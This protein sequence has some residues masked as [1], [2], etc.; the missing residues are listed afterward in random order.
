MTREAETSEQ[1]RRIGSR[2]GA[3]VVLAVVLLAVAAGCSNRQPPRFKGKEHQTVTATAGPGGVQRVEIEAT[4]ADRFVPDTIVVHPGKVTVVV[5]NT[6]AVPHTFEIPSL[7]VNTGN[8]GKLAV[9]SVT[10]R[11]EKPG[12]YSFD[13]AYHVTLHMD[14]TLQVLPG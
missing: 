4:D 9:K 6:G 1:M 8:I 13:C 10:F 14:G 7:H 3:L 11:V 12:S 5:R 2:A